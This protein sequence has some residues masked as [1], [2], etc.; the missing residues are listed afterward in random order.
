M[1]TDK[2]LHLIQQKRAMRS[3]GALP[4]PKAQVGYV[5]DSREFLK[6]WYDSPQY[7]EML[8]ASLSNEKNPTK[9]FKIIDEDRRYG[10]DTPVKSINNLR[11][12]AGA[13][14]LN[15]PSTGQ[16]LVDRQFIEQNPN[17]A[18]SLV[19]HELSHNS[20]M[21]KSDIAK[22]KSFTPS[23][24]PKIH[25][26]P[27]M[28]NDPKEN[29]DAITD[30]EEVRAMLYGLRN[31]AQ[32][33]NI[34]NPFTQS[35]PQDSLEKL[36][37][38]FQGTEGSKSYD[39]LKRLRA[40]YTDEQILNM[41][42]TI[43]DNTTRPSDINMAKLGGL[44]KAQD[45]GSVDFRLG[46][47]V[48]KANAL[49]QQNPF[50]VTLPNTAVQYIDFPDNRV[51]DPVVKGK[52]LESTRKAP[53]YDVP[54]EDLNKI[55]QQAN[56][57]GVDPATLVT[58]I[59]NE[60]KGGRTDENLGHAL[61]HR[62]P[63]VE[64]L[65]D[66]SLYANL[67]AQALKEQLRLGKLRYPE[68]PS[69]KQLQSYQG[70]GPLYPS[71]EKDYYGHENSAFFG[72]PVT[73][74]KPL[75]TNKLF[76]YGKTIE[77][78]RD[79]VIIPS[80]DKYSINYKQIGGLTMNSYQKGGGIKDMVVSEIW[81][82]VTGT[83]WSQAKKLGLSD[84]SY[85]TNLKLREMLINEAMQPKPNFGKF[86]GKPSS[87]VPAS[88]AMVNQ[89]R[90]EGLAQANIPRDKTGVARPMMSPVVGPVA[91]KTPSKSVPLQKIVMPTNQT[92]PA[93]TSAVA[94]PAMAPVMGR[95]QPAAPRSV[96][97]QPV[98]MPTNAVAPASTTAVRQPVMPP[99]VGRAT[100]KAPVT[101][102]P[103]EPSQM[104]N[105]L[106][107]LQAMQ[108][109]GN[110]ALQTGM[111]NIYNASIGPEIDYLTDP[112]SAV[113]P[114]FV[115]A[116]LPLPLNAANSLSY[117]MGAGMAMDDRSL[118]DEQKRM[119]YQ[120]AQ[121][122]AK[123]GKKSFTYEDYVDANDPS[124]DLYTK[125]LKRGQIG[126]LEAIRESYKNPGF[127]GA[128]TIGGSN[129]EFSP[130][131]TLKVVNVSDWNPEDVNFSNPNSPYQWYRNFLRNVNRN[132]IKNMTSEE[133]AAEDKK[134]TISLT[135]P[136]SI[137]QKQKTGG[138]K[139]S[140]KIRIKKS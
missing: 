57:V 29:Y 104:S 3:G 95:V 35:A 88:S 98:V 129:I 62:T 22:I 53:L 90:Q 92:A 41:L 97:T 112:N 86:I 111:E 106:A 107:A 67:A 23:Y 42:N 115:R 80:L 121:N 36:S 128:S 47:T 109:M 50:P 28:V 26:L 74:E 76:P 96:A 110:S 52:L 33:N 85:E 48:A 10:L 61:Y 138:A 130:D 65:D 137:M 122:A 45:A 58:I 19:S 71:T 91:P 8:A 34:Y 14:G 93:G 134:N 56:E 133:R 25:N 103:D 117:L 99:I 124:A 9:A 127:V 75:L 31:L 39:Q 21:P 12:K 18:S 27:G 60:T 54:R 83:K 20:A 55:I 24:N 108:L 132:R 120:T 4:L 116:A 43:S 40:Y 2:I 87:T 69:Y 119:I 139:R 1:K 82:K 131:G 38:L 64:G 13:F 84:G 30:P 66:F 59:V 81:E 16:V 51:T 94:R 135:I 105:P 140:L 114:N 118:S 125:K 72:I 46:P 17:L 123:K 89:L 73:K 78:Y 136:P 5:A 32:K 126:F 37:L 11:S 6:N 102:T 101:P 100:G 68:G 70:Y 113:L 44:P 79:S 7:K 77:Q 63:T 15:D 49:A